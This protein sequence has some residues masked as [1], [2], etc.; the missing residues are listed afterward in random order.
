[1]AENRASTS[2]STRLVGGAAEELLSTSGKATDMR[3]PTVFVWDLDETLIIFQTLLNG[4]FAGL[5]D[6]FKD[7]HKAMSLGRRWERLILE[8]CDDYFNYK[9]VI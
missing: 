7:S 9:Q 1:M 5:F 2:A 8:V 4:Q 3:G 6:G